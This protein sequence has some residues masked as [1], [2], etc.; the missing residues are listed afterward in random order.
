KG[1]RGAV[2]RDG[3]KSIPDGFLVN[4]GGKYKPFTRTGTGKWSIKSLVSPAIPQ[5][6]KNEEIV[7]IVEQKA[8]ERFEKRLDH[9]VMRMLRLYP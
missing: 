3:I 8:V 7:K 6:V 1:I 9:E 4:R 5:I 2:K